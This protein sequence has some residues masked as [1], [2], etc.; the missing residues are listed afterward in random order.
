M[1]AAIGRDKI[2]PRA[3]LAPENVN[4]YETQSKA[5]DGCLVRSIIAL[6]GY[7]GSMLCDG[8]EVT[9]S[10]RPVYCCRRL[11]LKS[12]LSRMKRSTLVLLHQGTAVNGGSKTLSAKRLGVSI[13]D[14]I[15]SMISA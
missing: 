8:Q 10:E 15:S 9:T 3:V 2:T 14:Y 6:W 7:S 11:V 4:L 12:G 1:P 5:Y 13:G